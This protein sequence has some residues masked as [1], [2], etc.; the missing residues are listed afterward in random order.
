M[1]IH[2]ETLLQRVEDLDKKHQADL[3][4]LETR[5]SELLHDKSRMDEFLCLR[6]KELKK[7][8]EESGQALRLLEQAKSQLIKQE[9]VIHGLQ[10]VSLS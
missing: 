3:A 8:K 1:K 10:R 6:D 7:V 4:S 2:I 9:D 5:I